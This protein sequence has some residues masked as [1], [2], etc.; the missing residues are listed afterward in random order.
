VAVIA[1]FVSWVLLHFAFQRRAVPLMTAI[2]IG[3]VLLALGLLFTFPPF[4]EMF[5]AE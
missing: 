5:T 3:G 4:F 1:F 2:I